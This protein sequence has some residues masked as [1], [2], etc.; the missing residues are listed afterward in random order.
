METGYFQEVIEILLCEVD[1]ID[2]AMA[3]SPTAPDA[4][5]MQDLRTKLFDAIDIL[6]D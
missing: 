3:S 6:E 1:K 2:D 5:A 4:E